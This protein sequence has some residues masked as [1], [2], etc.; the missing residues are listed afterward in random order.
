MVDP[1]RVRRVLGTLAGYRQRLD[2]LRRMPLEA[3]VE[4][5]AFAGR[6][7]VLASAQ[8]C[9]D[10]ANHVV[11]SERWRVP[12]DFEDAFTVLE[13]RQVLEAGLAERLRRLAGQRN[14]LVHLYGDID[15]ALIHRNLQTG[16]ED[17]DA[18]G[19]AIA[20]LV[21]PPEG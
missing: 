9:I 18:F 1:D 17:L 16:L 12:E 6:Y 7:L 8:A 20:R 11:A 4:E 13:E 10:L 14:R 3:Y 19:R 15:D 21:D 5:Q 2:R